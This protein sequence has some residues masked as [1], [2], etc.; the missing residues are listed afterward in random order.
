M[1]LVLLLWRSR[2]CRAASH[3]RSASCQ[4]GIAKP[5]AA[6]FRFDSAQNRGRGGLERHLVQRDGSSRGRTPSSARRFSRDVVPRRV[7]EF[8][9]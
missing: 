6:S 5:A 4:A 9:Q 7:P 8:T 3:R 2:A 1:Y